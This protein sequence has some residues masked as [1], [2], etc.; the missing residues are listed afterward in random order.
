MPDFLRSLAERVLGVASS[1]EPLIPS[2]FA[3]APDRAGDH[4]ADSPW[5][6]SPADASG[7]EGATSVNAAQ[8]LSRQP[9]PLVAPAADIAV[10]R[11]GEPPVV[12][13]VLQARQRDVPVA[14]TAP[15]DVPSR[16]TKQDSRPQALRP[17][18]ER[19]PA[20]QHETRVA[21]QRQEA[22]ARIS[23]EW[24]RPPAPLLLLESPSEPPVVRI[25]I[26]RIEVRATQSPP[27]EAPAGSP[28]P[29]PALSLDEYLSRRNRSASGKEPGNSG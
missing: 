16:S 20:A 24:P 27:A 2:Q 15:P 7:A 12:Q 17:A 18:V 6:E 23:P 11:E 5:G 25:T 13:P 10:A 3:P 28:R 4:S 26:G 21:S 9:V 19:V 29:R 1:I 8:A 14:H 22:P